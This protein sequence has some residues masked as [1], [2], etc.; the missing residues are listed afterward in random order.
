MCLCSFGNLCRGCDCRACCIYGKPSETVQVSVIVIG[1][2]QGDI[3][4]HAP[5]PPSVFVGLV[6]LGI[7]QQGESD[8]EILYVFVFVFELLFVLFFKALII[9]CSNN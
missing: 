8:D 2:R 9:I 4:C 6:C 3:I 1:I 7:R 5:T